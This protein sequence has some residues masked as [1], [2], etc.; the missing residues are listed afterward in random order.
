[1]RYIVSGYRR[2]GTSMMMNALCHGLEGVKMLFLRE[3]EETWGHDARIIDEYAPNPGGLREVTQMKYLDPEF[4]RSIPDQS[5]TKVMFDGLPALPAG[6][7]TVVFMHRDPDE[8]NASMDKF[9]D[10]IL[11][12]GGRSGIKDPTALYKEY[13]ERVWPFDVFTPYDQETLDHV[14]G[15]CEQRRDIRL[16]QV[17][18]GE[19]LADP[20]AAFRK[21]QKQGLHELDAYEAAKVVNPDYYRAKRAAGS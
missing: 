17:Q 21:L 8:I 6:E 7:W 13:D 11:K 16:F 10:Y 14:L 3:L 18:H 5:L 15:I 19:V 12:C 1:M 9:H 4:L 20:V 2:S